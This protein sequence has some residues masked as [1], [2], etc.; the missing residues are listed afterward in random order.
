MHFASVACAIF[1]LRGISG[2]YLSILLKMAR[3]IP[4]PLSTM[5]CCHSALAAV[6]KS[7]ILQL[8]VRS[9]KVLLANSGSPWRIVGG[10]CAV[11]KIQEKTNEFHK[12]FSFSVGEMHSGRHFCL[13]TFAV[14][15]WLSMDVYNVQLDLIIKNRNQMIDIHNWCS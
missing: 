10:L 11:V 5:P 3:K 14:Q 4:L 9:L 12:F 7:L 1:I 2:R 6:M 13:L 8:W 15:K